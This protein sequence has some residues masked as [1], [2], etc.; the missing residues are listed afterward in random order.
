M[1][2]APLGNKNSTAEKRLFGSALRRAIAQG[3][4]AKLREIADKIVAMAIEGDIQAIKEIANRLDGMV[5]QQVE[6]MGEGGG[7]VKIDA[8]TVAAMSDEEIKAYI[9]TAHKLSPPDDDS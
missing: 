3:D 2:G 7:P 6:V 9:A 5:R 1:A 4:G 8:K